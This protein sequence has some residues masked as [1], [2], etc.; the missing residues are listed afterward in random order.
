MTRRG[1]KRKEPE[2]SDAQDVSQSVP[3][4]P[5]VNEEHV[6]TN[7]METEVLPPLPAEDVWEPTSTAAAI[8]ANTAQEHIIDSAEQSAINNEM[9][10]EAEMHPYPTQQHMNPAELGHYQYHEFL[11]WLNRWHVYQNCLSDYWREYN[12][13]VFNRKCLELAEYKERYGDC[14][15]PSTYVEEEPLGKWVERIRA[16]AREGRLDVAKLEHLRSLGFD[17]GN[18]TV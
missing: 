6:A 9:P 16:E 1:T 13:D 10:H 18:D 3:S 12:K 17:F 11:D 2:P 14:N 8:A 7:N 15:V 4:C 5:M